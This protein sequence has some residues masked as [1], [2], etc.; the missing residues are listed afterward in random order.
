MPSYQRAIN[1]EYLIRLAT[2]ADRSQL[3]GPHFAD[4]YEGRDY[5]GS[6]VSDYLASP[7]LPSIQG[8]WR[9]SLNLSS[10][11]HSHMR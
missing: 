3:T 7:G 2:P 1:G 8:V 11:S 4:V 10:L 6:S 9:L 5:F